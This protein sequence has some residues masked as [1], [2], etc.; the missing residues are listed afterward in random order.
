MAAATATPQTPAP[1]P[2]SAAPERPEPAGPR[3]LGRLAMVAIGL[4]VLIGVTA[5]IHL[6]QGTAQVSA[7]DVLRWALGRGDDDA[8]AVVLA[9]RLPRL[10]AAVVVG[11]ALGAAGAAM[12]SVSR[13][14]MASPDTLAVNAGAHLALVTGATSGVALPLLGAA[15]V[16]F[17]GGLGAA[18]LVLALSGLGGTGAVRLVLAGSAI[19]LAFQALTSTQIIL[20]AEE[21]RG[22]FAWGSGSLGQNGLDGVRTL[23]LVAAVAFVALLA[24]GRKLDLVFLGDDHARMLGVNVRRVRVGAVMLAVLLSAAA[25]TL[26]GPIGFVGLAAPALVRLATSA[27]PGL[28]KHAVLLPV[29]AATGMLLLLASD[30][31][32]R[33]AIGAQDALEVPTG[34]I[35]T[36]FGALFLIA[37]ARRIRVSDAVR[38]PPAAGARGGVGRRRYTVIL[39]TLMVLTVAAMVAGVLLG[40]TRLLLGDVVNWL[41]GQAGPIVTGVMDTRLPRVGAAI[42]A[43]ASLALAGAVIQAVS[44]NPL[45]EPGIIGV[46]GGA[47]LGAIFTIT[48]VPLAGFWAMAG[49]AGVGA[50]LAAF[51]VFAL[52]ARGGFASDRLVLIG[53]AVS[54]GAQALIVVVITLSDPWNEVKALTWLAGSTYGRSFEHLLPM[55]LA[56]LAALPLLYSMRHS[57]DLLAVDDHTPRVLGV[58]VPR[59]RMVLL[60]CAVVLTGASVAGV[61]VITFVGLVAPHAARALVGRRHTR[62]LPVAALLGATLVCAADTLGRTVIAPAQLPAGLVTAIVGAPYFV[63]L[64]YRTRTTA[65]SPRRRQGWRARKQALQDAQFP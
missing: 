35:T 64:L 52:A 13:N 23:G 36:I 56:L 61:G 47:G 11:A 2:V 4:A 57:L 18:A 28:H 34:V 45:A 30:V 10:L 50:G 54:A 46:A 22:L 53:V 44:R 6:T 29:S 39:T 51:L 1:R 55:S 3:R 40:D 58:D 19:A 60:A 33:A 5:V 38:E 49:M 14:V 12:Q 32:L 37:L 26:A 31:M 25:V 17:V 24:L 21:T 7:G 42:L 16:A 62:V 15:G 20:F 65:N 27:V 9:S 59:A 63:W 41:S 43:G 48:L 8:S